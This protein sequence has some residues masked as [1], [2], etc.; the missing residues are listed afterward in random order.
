MVPNKFRRVFMNNQFAASPMLGVGVSAFQA[1]A[2]QAQ[3]PPGP[4]GPGRGYVSPPGLSLA[5]AES[6]CLS[7]ACKP[8]VEEPKPK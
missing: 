6:A 7:R 4:I 2:V 5:E 1:F 8:P 3:P